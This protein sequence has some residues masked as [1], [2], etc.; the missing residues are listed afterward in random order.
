MKTKWTLSLNGSKKWDKK[1]RLMKLL[2]LSWKNIIS[3][4][5]STLLSVLLLALGVGLIAFLLLLNKQTTEKFERNQGG[6]DLVL[7]AKGS[8]LQLILASIY[9]IDNPTGNIPLKSA[10]PFLNPKHPLVKMAVPLALGDSYKAY[11]IVGTNKDYLKVYDATIGEGKLWQKDF[12]VTIGAKVADLTGLKIGDEFNSAHGLGDA[13]MEHEDHPYRVVGILKKSKTVLDQLILTNIESVWAS[14]ADHAPAPSKGHEG[15][16]HHHD[17]AHDG[18]E[19]HDH[20]HAAHAEI[21]DEDKEITS[22]LVFYK[23]KTDFRALNLP[24]NINKNTDMQAAN[25]AYQT[26]RLFEMMGVGERALRFLAYAIV[27]VSALSVFISLFSSLK[28]RR[29]ELAIMRVMGGSR[30]KLFGL[31][32]LEGVLLALV[33][34]ILGILLAHI[35]MEVLARYM[36]DAYQYSF[37]GRD[38]LSAEWLLLLAALMIGFLSALIPAV[39]AS[40]TDI[41]RTLSKT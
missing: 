19:H 21:D 15:E 2:L 32:T 22:L 16:D 39:Q 41:S 11:R 28:D 33:G 7:G 35:G 34:G 17:H 4:P 5:L 26:A 30:G 23:N 14:H 20:D 36:Q 27:F 37:T 29:Y 31:L 18:H 38:F 8:P 12:E 6:V 25:P 10:R 24:N 3:K 40:K 13:I 1:N 9:H